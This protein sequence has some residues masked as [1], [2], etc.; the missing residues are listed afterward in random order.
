[1]NIVHPNLWDTMKAVLR[2][3]FGILS[4]YVKNI[5]KISH[6]RINIKTGSSSTWVFPPVVTISY[7]IYQ[8]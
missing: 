7:P 1:M 6:Y 2:G 4:A 5:G 8:V 3:T